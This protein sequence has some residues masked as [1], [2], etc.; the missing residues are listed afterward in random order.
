MLPVVRGLDKTC[1][2]IVAYTGLLVGSTLLLYPAGALG[3]FYLAVAVALGGAF[4]MQAI[5][6]L[7]DRSQVRAKS[8]FVYSNMYLA[9]LFASMVADRI[10]ALA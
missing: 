9:L 6:L 10:V 8:L 2:N 3:P 4:I 1:W 7:R 5:A